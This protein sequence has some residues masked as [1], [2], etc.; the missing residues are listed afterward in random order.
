MS[1]EIVFFDAGDTLL[2]AHPSFAELFAE[3]CRNAGHPLE[4]SA[5]EE[6]Q[7]SLGAHM[8]EVAYESG[9]EN[10]S[11]SYDASRKFWTALYRLLLQKLELD[12]ALA[13]DLV[14][15]FSDRSSYR[16][17]DDAAPVL[18]ELRQ[19]GYRIGLISNFESW[20]DDL[21]VELELGETFD[22]KIISAVEGIEKPD[23]RIYEAALARAGVDAE[24][25]VHVGDSVKFDIE[26]AERLGMY[27]ILL[28]RAGR[29]SDGPWHT[30]SSLEELPA[31]V[32][33][34]SR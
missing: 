3:T 12:E 30:I 11:L 26:P 23:L 19:R 24:A 25:A 18:H 1:V 20:L 7:K 15:V 14:E 17:F 29:H 34:I 21:L 32:E 13:E 5:V 4:A 33:N 31:H 8:I 2:H 22:V 16:L 6:V 27:P 9:I 10:P 28:D